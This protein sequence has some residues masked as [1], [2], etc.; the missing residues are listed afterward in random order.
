MSMK[1]VELP[2]FDDMMKL[3]EE[4]GKKKTALMLLE[5]KLDLTLAQITDT[6]T[7]G[8][9][10]W[11]N[12]KPPTNAHIKD[13][14]HILGV[15]DE[16]KVVLSNLRTEIARLTGDLKTDETLF[17]VY[18]EMINVWRTQSANESA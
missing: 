17:K 15:N 14:Y 11:I 5:S 16:T 10:Y 2:D 6:V 1:K 18:Q 7:N 8:E 12:N 13:T 3:A 4:I 9:A